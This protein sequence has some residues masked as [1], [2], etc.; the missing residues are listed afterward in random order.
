MTALRTDQQFRFVEKVQR[1]GKRRYVR[2]NCGHIRLT[3]PRAPVPVRA[4]CLDCPPP[5]PGEPLKEGNPTMWTEERIE[6]L[7]TLWAEGRTA[8]AIATELGGT[9]RNAV[10][11]KAHRLGLDSRPSPIRT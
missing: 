6:R 4:Y 11:G 7:K 5:T 8:S 3:N 1:V 10:L 9:T 2:L